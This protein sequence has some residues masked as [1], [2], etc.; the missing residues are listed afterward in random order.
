MRRKE[1]LKNGVDDFEVAT[2]YASRPQNLPASALHEYDDF[3]ALR[4]ALTHILREL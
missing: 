2:R 3:L 1:G 4:S